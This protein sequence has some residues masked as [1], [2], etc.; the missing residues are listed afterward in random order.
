MA[1]E[2]LPNGQIAQISETEED[3]IEEIHVEEIHVPSLCDVVSDR[4]PIARK[5]DGPNGAWL[6]KRNFLPGLGNGR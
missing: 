3:E 5:R 1:T 4:L 6:V 2:S